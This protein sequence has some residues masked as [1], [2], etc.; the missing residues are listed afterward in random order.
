MK[1]WPGS[2][3][4]CHN[5][6]D[7]PSKPRGE[8]R[9]PMTSKSE[10]PAETAEGPGSLLVLALL[11]PVAGAIAGLLALAAFLLDYVGRLWLP[12]ASVAW[13]SPFHYYS[14]LELVMGHPLP[15]KNLAVLAGIAALGLATAYVLFARRDISH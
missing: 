2:K 1:I 15:S 13:L 10:S 3:C 8:F 6:A 12:A 11:A 7:C 14:P 5:H 9:S 4:R